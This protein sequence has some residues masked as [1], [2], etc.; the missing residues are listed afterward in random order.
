MFNLRPVYQT[1]TGAIMPYQTDEQFI[2]SVPAHLNEQPRLGWREAQA[3]GDQLMAQQAAIHGFTVRRPSGL[4]YIDYWGV[5]SY[6]VESTLDFRR[7]GT[8]TNIWINGDTGEPG[9]W[10]C[11]TA[12]TSATR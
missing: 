8:A 11:R 7:R 9:W 4:A 1:V 3:R 5:Y 6:T 2:G 12:S 10:H